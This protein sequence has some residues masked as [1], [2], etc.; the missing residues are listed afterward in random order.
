MDRSVTGVWF[1]RAL[2]LVS[3]TAALTSSCGGG[4]GG[5]DATEVDPPAGG[6]TLPDVD[7]A[8]PIAQPGDV[9][10]EAPAREPLRFDRVTGA[11]HPGTGALPFADDASPGNPWLDWRF[12]LTLRAPDGRVLRVPGSFAG[13]GDGGQRGDVWSA[14]FTPPDEPGVWR[15]ELR[16]RSGLGINVDEPFDARGVTVF[17]ESFRFRVTPPTGQAKGLFARGVVRAAPD[18]RLRDADGRLF[19]KAGAGSPENLL[20]YVGFDGAVDGLDGGPPGE[21]GG[22]PDFL[23]TFG[24]QAPSWIPGDPDWAY[25]DGT[26]G[27]ARGLVGTL[28]ALAQLGANAIY[29]VPMNLGGDGRDSHPFFDNGGGGTS[30]DDPTHVRRYSVTRTEQWA[31]VLEFAQER[32]LFLQLVLAEREATNIAWLGAADSVER[33]LFQKQLVAWFGHYPGVEWTL[34]EENAAPGRPTLQQFTP[35]ELD[36]MARWIRAWDVDAHPRSVHTDPNDLGLFE[37]MLDADRADWLECASLQINGDRP[38]DGHLYGT[39]PE[40]LQALFR[41]RA[42]RTVVVHVDEPGDFEVGIASDLHPT[43]WQDV[44]AADSEDR[45]RRV[46]YDALFSG[47]GLQWYFGLWSLGDGGGDLTVE[48]LATRAAMFRFT[49]T[50]RTVYEDTFGG[51]PAFGPA[52]GLWASDAPGGDLHP[53]FGRAEVVAAP[54]GPAL[55][56]LPEVRVDGALALG[57]LGALDP[58][59]APGSRP[60]AFTAR[61][62]NPRLGVFVGDPAPVDPTLPFTPA[63]LPPGTSGDWLLVV[64]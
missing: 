10:F 29:V 28:R 16:L 42:G 15:A 51:A 34:C 47:A 19:V 59:A 5:A 20:G 46:L 18:G 52:D 61:W 57:T 54:G 38:G 21:A 36:G 62:M 2:G 11:R 63:P 40:E 6:P 56:Y 13:D 32:G 45:R 30:P 23:H 1:L 22:A 64:R 53:A 12:D 39:F 7:V 35:E 27:A 60:G 8:S 17:E 50:A 26:P 55:V 48:N 49:R 4:G 58:G 25:P 24:P 41:A 43:A 9:L 14:R 3:L 44:G 37:A 31:R 33:R